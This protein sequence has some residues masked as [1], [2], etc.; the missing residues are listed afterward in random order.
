ML[1]VAALVVTM[2]GI[3]LAGWYGGKNHAGTRPSTVTNAAAQPAAGTPVIPPSL[4]VPTT[5]SASRATSATATRARAASRPTCP[6]SRTVGKTFTV[7][8]MTDIIEHGLGA[9]SD[10][11]KPYMPVWHGIISKG[12]IND[13]V[14]YLNAGLPAV[15]VRPADRGPAPIRA[16]R[17]PDRSS[18]RTWAA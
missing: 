9:S 8:Q 2:V 15:E 5:S 13:I 6:R 18:T 11:K 14:D 10:P 16:R 7:A 12:Q 3:A 4:P 17:W 1:V